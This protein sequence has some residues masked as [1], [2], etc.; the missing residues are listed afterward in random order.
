MC[1][2]VCVVWCGVVGV[3]GCMR[4]R[5]RRRLMGSCGHGHLR[6]TPGPKAW[7][8]LP[9]LWPPRDMLTVYRFT[10][11][12]A[13][14]S[15][16]G[17]PASLCSGCSAQARRGSATARCTQ[18]QGRR[19]H[20]GLPGDPYQAA[21]TQHPPSTRRSTHLVR[22]DECLGDGLL[23]GAVPLPVLLHV[24]EQVGSQPL[25]S[26]VPAVAVKHG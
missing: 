8:S 16:S 14:A 9:L 25:G 15:C 5:S 11:P 20:L 26:G 7:P 19:T 12:R 2:C 4:R 18:P 17:C 1:V 24:V 10:S 22:L 3:E 13:Q 6:L 21:P 23:W